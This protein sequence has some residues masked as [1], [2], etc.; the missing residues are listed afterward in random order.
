M[1]ITISRSRPV[2]TGHSDCFATK[3]GKCLCLNSNDFG[4][5]GCPFFRPNT[6][7]SYEKIVEECKAYAKTHSECREG[8][9]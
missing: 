9:D 4:K 6:E 1:E 8:D 7:L 2:C 3:G 5:R